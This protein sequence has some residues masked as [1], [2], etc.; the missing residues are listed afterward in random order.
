MGRQRD[1]VVSD[2]THHCSENPQFRNHNNNPPPFPCISSIPEKNSY[3]NSSAKISQQ[4]PF[5]QS[6]SQDSNFNTPRPIDPT[7]T[8]SQS[9]ENTI[10]KIQSWR[11][12]Q[13]K[14]LTE[15]LQGLSV[16]PKRVILGEVLDVTAVARRTAI[17]AAAAQPQLRPLQQPAPPPPR[18]PLPIGRI[19]GN[20][21][22]GFVLENET[23]E[24]SNAGGKNP[25]S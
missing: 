11:R 4:E 6:H 9:D 8:E 22:L 20:P 5:L 13:E 12:K 15:H 25:T 1:P 19:E 3:F 18:S 2:A 14:R 17:R 10:V 16:I 7:S 23:V 24:T 21:R